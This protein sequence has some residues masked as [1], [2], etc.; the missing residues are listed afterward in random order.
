MREL[1][2]GVLAEVAKVHPVT[3]RQR[4]PWLSLQ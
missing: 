3:R 1:F 2:V 4:G